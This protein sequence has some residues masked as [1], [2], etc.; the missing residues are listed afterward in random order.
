MPIELLTSGGVGDYVSGVS[1]I[2]NSATTMIT[3]NPIAAVFIGFTLI[4]AGIGL[5]RKVT[6]KRGS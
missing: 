2:F 6:A 5:F 4:G 1:D 3:G